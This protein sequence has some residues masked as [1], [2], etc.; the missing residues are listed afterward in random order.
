MDKSALES[1]YWE[2]KGRFLSSKID[3]ITFDEEVR[4]LKF[5]DELG[6]WNRLGSEDGEWYVF[7][8][9]EWILNVSQ[10]ESTAETQMISVKEKAGIQ[11]DKHE[12]MD[13]EGLTMLDV[14]EEDDVSYA[15]SPLTPEF[16]EAL[17]DVTY[18]EGFEPPSESAGRKLFND[19]NPG[20]YQLALEGPKDYFRAYEDERVKVWEASQSA[21][22]RNT[23]PKPVT[24]EGVTG[25]RIRGDMPKTPDTAEILKLFSKAAQAVKNISSLVE[26][27]GEKKEAA[28]DKKVMEDKMASEDVKP[29]KGVNTAKKQFCTQC[30]AKLSESSKFC[31]QCGHKL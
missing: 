5:Q 23:T 19:E 30:G 24:A 3:R 20:T 10:S 29:V 21:I 11:T 25:L 4:K 28:S 7:N 6:N 12:D 14:L 1:K 18:P 31:T 26:Q 8:G 16:E 2:L 15:E 22:D 13:D 17:L 27:E 9:D